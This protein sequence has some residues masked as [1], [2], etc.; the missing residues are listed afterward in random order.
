MPSGRSAWF[1]AHNDK[2][3]ASHFGGFIDRIRAKIESGER[4][5]AD[6]GESLF[7]SDVDLHAVGELLSA[8]T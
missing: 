7:R 1:Q 3:A 6:D 5:T 4:L 2:S 8:C